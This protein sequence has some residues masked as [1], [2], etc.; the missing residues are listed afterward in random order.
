MKAISEPTPS[1][2]SVEDFEAA[3]MRK[4]KWRI[5]PLIVICY[6]FAW[7]DRIN[8]SFA[9][10]H[11]QS[12]LALSNTA[13]GLGA[14]LFVVG[15][16]LCEVPSNSI[17]Y[18]VGARK[19]IARIMATWGIATACMVFV[20][21]ETQFYIARFIIGAAEAGFAPGILYYLS[22]WFPAKQKGRV[23]SLLYIALAASGIIGAPISGFILGNFDGVAGFA[24]WHWLF[25]LGGIPC[26]ILAVL[27][28]R[29]F[30]DRVEDAKFLT[31]E[32]KVHLRALLDKDAKVA[33]S[34]T[35]LAAIKS[36]AFIL[37]AVV[38]FLVQNASYAMNFWMPQMIRNSGFEDAMTIGWLTALPYLLG[39]VCM[40]ILGAYAD[41]LGNRRVVFTGCML[42]TLVGFLGAAYFAKQPVYLM[43]SLTIMGIGILTTIPTFWTLPQ[44]IVTGSG[45]AAGIALI[46]SCGQLGGVVSPLMIGKI[47][48][49][50]GSTTLALYLVAG[51]CLICAALLFFGAPQ[52]LRRKEV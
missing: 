49:A 12:D 46:N 13:Y 9:K 37:L 44:K 18:R 14:S 3:L 5:I 28:L 41:R 25:L 16:V 11:M 24:G 26:L 7:Y 23:S 20:Q 50:T 10:F 6:L 36:P 30:V 40:L 35:L 19:W 43:I 47:T 29:T 52:S 17:L 8:I 21:T 31:D 32:E 34:H 1:V 2:R 42:V 4:V 38:Y 33:E 45:A 15:Y 27:V 51:L 39:G 48:D 22:T